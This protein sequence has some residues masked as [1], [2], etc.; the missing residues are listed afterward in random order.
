MV[1]DSDCGKKGKDSRGTFFGIFQ[2]CWPEIMQIINI[3]KDLRPNLP[4]FSKTIGNG[5]RLHE[6]PENNPYINICNIIKLV[7]TKN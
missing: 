5:D 2:K 6:Q 7:I 3:T 4:V 1:L